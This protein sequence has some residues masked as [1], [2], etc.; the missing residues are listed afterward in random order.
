MR[1]SAY[2][3]AELRGEG[4]IQVLPWD[5]VVNHGGNLESS[6]FWGDKGGWV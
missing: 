3:F 2:A 4:Q 1:L 5:S 6:L